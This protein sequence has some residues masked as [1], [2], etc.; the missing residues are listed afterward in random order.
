MS[1]QDYRDGLCVGCRA[2]MSSEWSWDRRTTSVRVLVLADDIALVAPT[3]DVDAQQ[4]SLFLV[5]RYRL[6]KEDA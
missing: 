5:S 6:T 1:Y 2:E 3:S 4:P